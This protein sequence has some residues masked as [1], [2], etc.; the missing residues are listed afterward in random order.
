MKSLSPT[1]A[2]DVLNAGNAILI[3]VREQEEYDEWHIEGAHL[4][5]L[6][7]LP[8]AIEAINFPQDKKI[9]FHCLKG[10][11]SAQAIDFLSENI[12]R[13]LDVYNLDDGILAWHQDGLPIITP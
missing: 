7:I 9:I 12:L 5:P 11:R 10:G 4:V 3:D 8:S 6:S 13:G 1:E 2:Y